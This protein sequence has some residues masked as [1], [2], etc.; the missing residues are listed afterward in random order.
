MIQ[1]PYVGNLNK[2]RIIPTSGRV[3]RTQNGIVQLSYDILVKQ[4]GVGAG[5]CFGA[6]PQNSVLQFTRAEGCQYA[7]K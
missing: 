1:I 7:A 3:V 5:I 2:N 6:F 4:N